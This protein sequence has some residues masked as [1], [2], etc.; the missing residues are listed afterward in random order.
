M[1]PKEWSPKS[2]RLDF[3]LWQ[4]T[5][6]FG[7]VGFKG[8]EPTRSPEK[9]ERNHMGSQATALGGRLYIGEPSRLVG[10]KGKLKGTPATF[11]RQT[12]P[13]GPESVAFRIP[14]PPPTQCR[15]LALVAYTCFA[16][17]HKQVGG[18]LDNNVRN[19]QV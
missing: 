16:F 7:F 10:F 15:Q 1:V 5:L 2:V 13:F 9:R 12:Q 8:S 4:K 18:I 11:P 6:R 17:V 19:A 14:S 3:F